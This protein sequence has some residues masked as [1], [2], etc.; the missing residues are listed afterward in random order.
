VSRR[1]RPGGRH[2]L[3]RFHPYFIMRAGMATHFNR[4]PG[5]PI[6]IETYVHLVSDHVAAARAAG[7]TLVEMRERRIDDRWIALKPRWAEY[8]LHPVSFTTVWHRE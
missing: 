3:V 5:E 7:L 4:R 6:A 2:V 1:A 8:A